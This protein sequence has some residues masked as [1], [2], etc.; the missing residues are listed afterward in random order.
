MHKA[1]SWH[2]LARSSPTAFQGLCNEGRPDSP[3][4]CCGKRPRSP[5]ATCKAVL[6]Q[7]ASSAEVQLRWPVAAPRDAGRPITGKR[8]L[9]LHLP[10]G[11]GMDLVDNAPAVVDST[12]GASSTNAVLMPLLGCSLCE[13]PGS[14]HLRSVCAHV[15]LVRNTCAAPEHDD[16][17]IGTTN[18]VSGRKQGQTTSPP[19]CGAHMPCLSLIRHAC[20]AHAFSRERRAGGP[21]SALPKPQRA[22]PTCYNC[23]R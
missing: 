5:C 18:H 7:S 21:R 15:R 11:L 2:T 13:R 6:A 20:A 10:G 23:Q 9:C 1:A 19:T 4:P 17:R 22:P 12:A 8:L 14:G 16:D 3:Q